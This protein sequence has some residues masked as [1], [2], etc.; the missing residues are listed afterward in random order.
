MLLIYNTN[1][2]VII[3]KHISSP[4]TEDFWAIWSNYGKP[5]GLIDLSVAAIF[6]V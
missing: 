5:N 6:F 3:D 4:L 1:L 2:V